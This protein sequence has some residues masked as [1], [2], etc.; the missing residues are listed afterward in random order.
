MIDEKNEV[1][2]ATSFA[3][4]RNPCGKLLTR[5]RSGP[6]IEPCGIPASTSDHFDD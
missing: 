6:K 4:Q 3:L 2:S 5:K 1:S